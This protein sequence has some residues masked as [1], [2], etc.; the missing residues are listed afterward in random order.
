MC[1]DASDRVA[2]NCA[3]QTL[4]SVRS[5]DA[6]GTHRSAI[7]ETMAFEPGLTAT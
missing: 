5:F 4:A 3:L 6:M 7:R 1:D 2:E